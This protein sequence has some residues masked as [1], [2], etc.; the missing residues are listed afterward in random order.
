MSDRIT[1]THAL[2]RS[3]CATCSASPR[4]RETQQKISS[5]KELTTPSDDPFAVSRRSSCAASVAREP[6]VPAQRRARRRRGRSI[7]D[8]ALVERRPTS[9]LRARDLVVQGANDTLGPQAARQRS[10]T[11]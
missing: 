9:V 2:R 8:T 7:T 6:A 4:C 11:R 10:R 1:Q 5:G 3:L